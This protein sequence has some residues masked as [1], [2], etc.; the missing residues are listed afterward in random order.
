VLLSSGID[1]VG[2]NAPIRVLTNTLVGV[3]PTTASIQNR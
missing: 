3:L 2:S 1:A